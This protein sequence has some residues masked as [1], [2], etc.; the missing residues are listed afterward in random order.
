MQSADAVLASESRRQY[1]ELLRTQVPEHRGRDDAE[2]ETPHDLL[3]AVARDL[4]GVDDHRAG[5]AN[6]QITQRLPLVPPPTR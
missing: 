2:A 5:T 1:L 4:H 6:P 3:L